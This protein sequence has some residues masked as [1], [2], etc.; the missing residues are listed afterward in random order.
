MACLA[1]W[2]VAGLFA[3]IFLWQPWSCFPL[4]SFLAGGISHLELAMFSSPPLLIVFQRDGEFLVGIAQ[5]DGQWAFALWGF[6]L[7]PPL[8][9]SP[10]HT[11]LH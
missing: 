8:V 3:C 2:P 5:P 9:V 11:H 6:L 4:L 7:P 10:S 1:S